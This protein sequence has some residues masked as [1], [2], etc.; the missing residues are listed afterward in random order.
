PVPAESPLSATRGT[1]APSCRR[2]AIPSAASITGTLTS[3]K[4]PPDQCTI[5]RPTHATPGSIRLALSIQANGAA[6]LGLE[7]LV[8]AGMRLVLGAFPLEDDD[9]APLPLPLLPFPLLPWLS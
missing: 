6:P 2:G 7:M 4:P 8:G 5:E 9:T 1:L 3:V